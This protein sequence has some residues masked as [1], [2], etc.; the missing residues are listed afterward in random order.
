[1]AKATTSTLESLKLVAFTKP[2]S[3]VVDPVMMRRNAMVTKLNEQI[4]LAQ[5]PAF[6]KVLR[7]RAK[8]EETGKTEYTNTEHKVQ[9]MWVEQQDGSVIFYVRVGYKAIELGAKGMTG[10]HCPRFDQLPETIQIIIGAVKA[11]ELDKQLEAA[12][13]EVAKKLKKGKK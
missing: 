9:P 2:S 3:T 5:N 7:H 4:E 10:I 1:M 13:A 12:S 8:N 11:G 6:R